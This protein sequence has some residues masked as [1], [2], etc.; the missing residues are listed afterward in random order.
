MKNIRLDSLLL[1]LIMALTLSSCELAGDI[2][3][4]GAWTAILGIVLVIALIV[5][6]FRKLIS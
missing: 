1:V 4:A 6:L 2:F 5:W 3:E